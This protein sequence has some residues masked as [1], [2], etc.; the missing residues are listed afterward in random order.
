MPPVWFEHSKEKSGFVGFVK[1]VAWQGW[2][3][4]VAM[5]FAMA[6]LAQMFGTWAL[7]N[8]FQPLGVGVWLLAG[9]FVVLGVYFKAVA[10][11]SG[12]KD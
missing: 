11:L 3:V 8:D 1:P 12:P 7:L 5:V 10:Y 2:V 9:A 6:M 4:H